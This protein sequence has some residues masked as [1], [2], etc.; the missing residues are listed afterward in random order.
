L[1]PI[2]RAE[3]VECILASFEFSS[4][5][6]IDALWAKEVEDRIDAFERGELSTTSAQDVFSKINQ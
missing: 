3:L 2:E 6:E 1:S 5:E 4:R